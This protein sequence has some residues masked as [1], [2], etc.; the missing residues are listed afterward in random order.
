MREILFRGKRIDNRKWVY[1]DLLSYT[2][3]GFDIVDYADQIRMDNH[4]VIPET[5][6]Q[7]TGLTDKNGK[8]IFEG[9]I[10]S[11]NDFHGGVYLFRE[12]PKKNI[13]V[14]YE[15]GAILGKRA[16]FSLDANVEKG[17]YCGEVI[18]NIYDNPELLSDTA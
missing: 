14:K 16:G 18:G 15:V 6:G 9:D 17:V 10:V 5:V 1:G 12:Q 3:G 4:R 8:K 13:V 7:F 2:T 11:E